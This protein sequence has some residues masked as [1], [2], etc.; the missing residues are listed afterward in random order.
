MR[1][2]LADF[3]FEFGDG[4]FLKTCR[5]FLALPAAAINRDQVLQTVEDGKRVGENFKIGRKIFLKKTA[6]VADVFARAFAERSKKALPIFSKRH[7][8]TKALRFPAEHGK[9]F[10]DFLKK[11]RQIRRGIG[12]VFQ[13]DKHPV[14]FVFLQMLEK[15]LKEIRF[16]AGSHDE[17]EIIRAF[18]ANKTEMRQRPAVKTLA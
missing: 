14:A 9:N 11:E 8:H 7:S 3:T 10:A 15:L 18:L 13:L 1:K 16:S 4:I 6:V 5:T 17:I 2:L 12:N